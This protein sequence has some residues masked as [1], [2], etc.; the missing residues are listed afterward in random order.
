M[1]VVYDFSVFFRSYAS[2]WVVSIS[3]RENSLLVVSGLVHFVYGS[4]ETCS[5]KRLVHTCYFPRT[6]VNVRMICP[7]QCFM[8]D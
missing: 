1:A 3:G 8:A 5:A 2:K 7:R 6:G 4:V